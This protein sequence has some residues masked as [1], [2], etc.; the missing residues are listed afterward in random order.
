MKK[1]LFTIFTLILFIVLSC[2][3]DCEKEDPTL[4]LRN[5]GPGRAD[6]QI[7]TSGGNTENVNNI[8]VGTTSEKR[9]FSPGDIE[10][11]FSIQG[12]ANSIEYFLHI[13]YCTDYVVT[14]QPDTTIIATKN[15]R[16]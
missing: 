15:K 11:T 14:I 3:D 9:S 6:V 1:H 12:V 16:D 7:K 13:D 8:E 10:F 2:S 5:N 4:V